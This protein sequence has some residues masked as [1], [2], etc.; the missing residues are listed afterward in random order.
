MVGEF[1]SE[2]IDLIERCTRL[3][4]SNTNT[5]PDASAIKG[6]DMQYA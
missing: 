4:P 6:L 5:E 1:I 3:R 2:P